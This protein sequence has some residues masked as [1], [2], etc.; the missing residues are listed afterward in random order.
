MQLGTPPEQTTSKAS[1]GPHPGEY[2]ALGTLETMHEVLASRGLDD[3]PMD[4]PD[5]T[6]QR[7]AQLTYKS[8]SGPNGTSPLASP[9]HHKATVWVVRYVDYTSK[10]GLGFLLNTGSAGVYFNDSTKIVLSPDGSIFQYVE[11]R[12]RDPQGCPSGSGSGSEHTIQTH[13]VSYYPSELQKKVTLL[14]HFRNYLVDQ[15]REGASRAEDGSAAGGAHGMETIAMASLDGTNSGASSSVPFGASSIALKATD[16]ASM[17]CMAAP[18]AGDSEMPF[19]KKWVRTR[20]A[21]LFRLSNRT[22]QVLFFD[23]SEVLLSSEARMV[24]YVNKQGVRSEHSL[25]EVLQT[26]RTDIAKRLKYAKD[27]MYRLIST[28]AR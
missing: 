18:F 22:V 6:H 15:Q 4:A 1:N 13:L 5:S 2:K 26:G 21:I 16:A 27:I 19:L 10:Y 9:L 23:R 8:S 12:R 25:E 24:T 3:L 17:G 28:Q 11:R 14:R 20:H 7:Q